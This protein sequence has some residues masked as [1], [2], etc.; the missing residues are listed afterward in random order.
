MNTIS[1][2]KA[3]PTV[4]PILC[5]EN[6]HTYHFAKKLTQGSSDVIF[7]DSLVFIRSNTYQMSRVN[8]KCLDATGL[9]SCSLPGRSPPKGHIPSLSFL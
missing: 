2:L 3:A 4:S 1:V 5:M 9:H 8:D 7:F 6:D